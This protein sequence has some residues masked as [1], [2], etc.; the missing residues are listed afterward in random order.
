MRRRRSSTT[1]APTSPHVEGPAPNVVCGPFR[2]FNGSRA[3]YRVAW[4]HRGVMPQQVPSV[5]VEALPDGVRMLD[6]REPDEWA[7]GHAPDA[8]HIPLG[9][10]AGRLGELASDS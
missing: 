6:V 1:A 7:A 10:L 4:Q 3:S 2:L 8:V 5:T 9:E